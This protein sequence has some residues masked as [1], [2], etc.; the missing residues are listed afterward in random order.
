MTTRRPHVLPTVV[1]FALFAVAA[2][3]ALAQQRGY[4]QNPNWNRNPT[5]FHGDQPKP[6]T[7]MVMVFEGQLS[8]TIGGHQRIALTLA[9][10]LGGRPIQALIPN[11]E[12]STEPNPEFMEKVK[13]LQPGESLVRVEVEKM[14]GG[15]QLKTLYPIQLKHGE[16][17]PNAFVFSE[18]YNDPNSGVPIVVLT[19][20]GERLEV[21]IASV[22][23]DKGKFA[24][25]PKVS[26]AIDKLK[27]GDVIYA[28][29]LPGRVPLLAAVYPYKDPQTG[30]LVKVTE[31]DMDGRKAPA[32]EIDAAD[33]S[34]VTAFVP[35]KLVNKRWVPDQMMTRQVRSIRPGSEVL[36]VTSDEAGKTLLIQIAKA[37]PAPREAPAGARDMREGKP[38]N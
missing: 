23:D 15:Y 5:G 21:G 30:K 24:P 36:Y 26:E 28:T 29:V 22:R 8:G 6:P 1:A 18:S 4:G 17:T 34:K 13:G 32:A 16:K 38:R 7:D 10:V 33:G 20:Y 2:A 31:Q 25:D 19:K 11:K 37:P 27:E 9:P 35:G 14:Y 12:K 3:P